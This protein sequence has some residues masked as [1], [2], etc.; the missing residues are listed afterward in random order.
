[1]R[2]PKPETAGG[3]GVRVWMVEGDGALREK[4]RGGDGERQEGGWR[5]GGGVGVGGVGKTSR[6]LGVGRTENGRRL[7]GVGLR[8][9]SKGRG[10]RGTGRGSDAGALDWAP[11]RLDHSPEWAGYA[12]P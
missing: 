2:E 11:G 6:G 1:M 10:L 5:G 3:Q 8:S 12:D 7:T 4:A 9:P